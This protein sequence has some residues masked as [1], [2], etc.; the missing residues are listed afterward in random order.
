MVSALSVSN[1]ILRQAWIDEIDITQMKLQKLLYILYKEFLK[2]T[3][4]PL[5]P[6]RFE[7]WKYGPV[8]SIVQNAFYK[9][10]AYAIDEYGT[11]PDGYSYIIQK[12]S[13]HTFDEIF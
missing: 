9:Y 7:A 12:N 8:I 6:E 11:N 4:R 2:R 1:A 13:S 10:G 5:F 3:G